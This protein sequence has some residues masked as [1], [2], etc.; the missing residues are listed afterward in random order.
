MKSKKNM[1]EKTK[2]NTKR[3]AKPSVQL[4]TGVFNE[5]TIDSPSFRASVNYCHIKVQKLQ[6]WINNTTDYVESKYNEPCADFTRVNE[7]FLK[8]FLP[9]PTLLS[10]GFVTNQS[11][12]P[13]F[14]SDFEKNYTEF[15]KTIEKVVFLPETDYL[16]LLKELQVEVVEQYITKH[17]TF[18][19]RQN[20]Y[21]SMLDQIL[22]K[23][24]SINNTKAAYLKE[25]EDRL[26]Q[27]KRDY[28]DVSLDLIAGLESLRLTMDKFLMEVIGRFNNKDV[29]TFK[30]SGK[31]INLSPV[32]NHH[33]QSYSNWVKN[34]ML[35]FKVV[36]QSM[37]RLKFY[38]YNRMIRE[39]TPSDDQ[40]DY[41]LANV[42]KLLDDS[43]SSH[44]NKR[45]MKNGW[46]LMKATSNSS[47][48]EMWV[49]RWCSIDEFMFGLFL[50]SP[51]KTYVEETDK[52]GIGLINL[53][54]PA[55]SASRRFCFNLE[56]SRRT[57]GVTPMNITFQ[58]KN[59]TQLK[60]WLIAFSK[61]KLKFKTLM[62]DASKRSSV[63]YAQKRYSPQ[64]SEFASTATTYYDQLLTNKDLGTISLIERLKDEL[65]PEQ[66][67]AAIEQNTQSFMSVS[68]P[69]NTQMT[70]L[71]LLSGPFRD[72]SYKML[73]AIQANIWGLN[74]SNQNGAVS[75]ILDDR[76]DNFQNDKQ[77]KTLIFPKQYTDE[78]KLKYIQF[79][80]IFESLNYNDDV[81]YMSYL[82]EFMLVRIDHFWSFEK[83]QKFMCV[84]YITRKYM[85]NYM[86]SGGI[87]HLSR[88]K[89]IDYDGAEFRDSIKGVVFL[90]MK[91]KVTVRLTVFHHNYKALACK[92][93]YLIELNATK[94]KK[95]TD[96]ILKKFSEID[97]VY[98]DITVMEELINDPST[99]KLIKTEYNLGKTFWN[100]D[101]STE[102]L[103]TRLNYLQE[104]YSK[105]YVRNYDVPSKALMHIM[106]GDNSSVFPNS[107]YWAVND[108]KVSK[109]VHWKQI[110]NSNGKIK[111]E[112][113]IQFKQ[114]RTN[115]FIIEKDKYITL[116]QTITGMVENKYY[117]IE[118]EPII[119]RF[120]FCAPLKIT[121]LYV[122]TEPF[123]SENSAASKLHLSTNGC[124]LYV[125][126][127]F[128]FIN[129]KRICLFERYARNL[130]SRST[131]A[132]FNMIKSSIHYYLER[133]GSHGQI[134]RAV[135]LGGLLGVSMDEKTTYEKDGSIVD[136]RELNFSDELSEVQSDLVSDEYTINSSKGEKQDLEPR[137]I[138]V[139]NISVKSSSNPVDG[140][141][142]GNLRVIEYDWLI[143]SRMS[144]KLLLYRTM[145]T[146]FVFLR[147]FLL[148][149][150][151]VVKGIKSINFYLLIG[152][153]ISIMVNV[154][155]VS[156]S[157]IS[158]WS[159]RKANNLFSE[160]M[161]GSNIS[162]MNR[163][164]S[165]KDLDILSIYLAGSDKD[166]VY[167]KY[168]QTM[169][170]TKNKYRETRYEIGVRRND[171]LVELRILQNMEKELVQGDYRAFLL[172][173]IN[174]CKEV[175]VEYPNIWK[176]D[177][178]LQKYCNLC[179]EEYER[180]GVSL[181]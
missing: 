169:E 84:S 152:L 48:K 86:S 90:H 47:N 158:Y 125:F 96:E 75:S 76:N 133:I 46:L 9:S 13:K 19:Y 142:D 43:S 50:L 118:Q 171:L 88:L 53:H 3:N 149:I 140:V 163:A 153:I 36:H 17:K 106:F 114:T 123:S 2:E 168:K 65:T 137:S 51:N 4:V 45:I 92:L 26:F 69:I 177:N 157:G 126:Y 22:S 68:A 72:N 105:A 74:P 32:I 116:S 62:E 150:G 156:R 128:D 154:Y 117:Q 134:T 127:K 166:D 10:N 176:D 14:V 5:A 155:M 6:E 64:F 91:N 138:D 56:I 42:S 71:A 160:I 159:V 107:I 141:N 89:L 129:C 124:R 136:A 167:A 180:F 38:E 21:D 7:V 25:E 151:L 82:D 78:L 87:F 34:S 145:N 66:I 57:S 135:K 70:L 11:Y 115:S 130:V 100:V 97:Q 98:K 119:I 162:T 80:T 83:E 49:R 113:L 173:E 174:N 103:T 101:S 63:A 35:S 60:E 161:T 44:S 99:N 12:A 179:R 24:E 109:S 77:P 104:K 164:I 112:R 30:E 122:I 67:T 79:K 148:T 144:L 37:N 41:I 54:Y 95:T 33:F 55:S 181:L 85:Y 147:F 59:V 172:K 93:Q 143:L 94:E 81:K 170:G 139:E 31:Q 132:E 28:I 121:V 111:M 178:Q 18:E 61:S 131:E 58:A 16:D 40:N 165:I 8:Q 102:E 110:Q 39:L 20:E 1:K 146:L 29:Y 175:T 108:S 52:F 120:P 15:I 73:D 23:P 27:L